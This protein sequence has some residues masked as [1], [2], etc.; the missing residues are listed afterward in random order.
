MMSPMIVT[1][2]YVS[3]APSNTASAPALIAILRLRLE[4]T[5]A[6]AVIKRRVW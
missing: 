6:A 5:G 1:T 3:S 2:T 4:Y